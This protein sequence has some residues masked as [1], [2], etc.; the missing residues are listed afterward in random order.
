[1]WAVLSLTHRDEYSYWL[2]N[3]RT[4]SERLLVG[5]EVFKIKL[6]LTIHHKTTPSEDNLESSII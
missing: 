6:E 3:K 4:H 1:M 2:K 5:G